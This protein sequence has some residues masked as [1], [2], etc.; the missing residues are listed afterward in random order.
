MRDRTSNL[1]TPDLDDLELCDLAAVRGGA[2]PEA[3]PTL[4]YTDDGTTLAGTRLD[5][6]GGLSN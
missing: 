6:N 3:A 4:A 1:P 2:K 5:G